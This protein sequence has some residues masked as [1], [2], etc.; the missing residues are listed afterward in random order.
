MASTATTVVV[1]ADGTARHANTG[2]LRVDL[3]PLNAQEQYVRMLMYGA[4][5]YGVNNWRRGLPWVEVAA[6]LERHVMQ[7]M[8]G[9]RNDAES[10]LP[11]LAH[12]MCNAAF[13]IEYG[14]CY[15]QG[16]NRHVALATPA[17]PAE[18]SKTT[19]EPVRE[20]IESFATAERS[21]AKSET[22]LRFDL[23]PLYAQEQYVR[24]LE[25]A[26]RKHCE[27]PERARMSVDDTIASLLRHLHAWKKCENYDDLSECMH[28]AHIMCEA[29]FLLEN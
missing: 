19:G 2:K 1:V 6:S 28:M 22:A 23:V 3:V 9:E 11:H 12:V 13:I 26:A 18:V 8:K 27:S 15:P 29:A 21:L 10:G 7:W 24:A 5:K 14:E 4:Q 17:F 20:T 16:D 25:F